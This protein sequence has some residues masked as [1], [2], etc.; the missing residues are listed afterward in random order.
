M[1][2][3]AKKIRD[4]DNS[5]VS[6]IGE[7]EAWL[8]I[9]KSLT[10]TLGATE[11]KH[12]AT[13]IHIAEEAINKARNGRISESEMEGVIHHAYSKYKHTVMVQNQ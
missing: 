2:I 3:F 10:E 8:S 11:Q 7:F 12:G 5:S 1:S 6:R 4:K 9:C 13:M